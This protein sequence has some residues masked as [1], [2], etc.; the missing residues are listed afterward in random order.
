MSLSKYYI[1]YNISIPFMVI[2]PRKWLLI[3]F[4][5]YGIPIIIG[6]TAFPFEA[7]AQN[8]TTSTNQTS[9][10]ATNITR[11]DFQPLVE[12]INSAREAMH[13]NNTHTAYI[14]LSNMDD[15]IFDLTHDTADDVAKMEQVSHN[16]T[17]VQMLKPIS[18]SIQN[19]KAAL[20]A[21]DSSKALDAINTADTDLVKIT[22]N[23]ATDETEDADETE[24]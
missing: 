23:L 19:A 6:L 11:G 9:A 13:N 24:E 18:E 3:V 16:Q 17:I 8:Q 1:E 12:S 2:S 10:A 7:F 5:C 15:E 22:Q 14:Q 20:D 4:V 21:D